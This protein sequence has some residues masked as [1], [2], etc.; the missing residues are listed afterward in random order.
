MHA[1]LRT[2]RF[3]RRLNSGTGGRLNT[4][5]DCFHYFFLHWPDS[6]CPMHFPE[7]QMDLIPDTDQQLPLHILSSALAFAF[8]SARSARSAAALTASTVS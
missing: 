5:I 8:C 6:G 1:V 4:A 3:L 2:I 7:H